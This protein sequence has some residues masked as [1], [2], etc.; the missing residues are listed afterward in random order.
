TAPTDAV[1]ATA[2]APT[3]APPAG[4]PTSGAPAPTAEEPP[5][6]VPPTATQPFTPTPTQEP[7]A[8]KIT[9]FDV[10]PQNVAPGALVTVTWQIEEA[11]RVVIS[12]FGDVP[13]EGQRQYRLDQTTDFQLTATAPGGKESLRVVHIPVR[14]LP[15][16]ST[17][18][19]TVQITEQV[20]AFDVVNGTPVTKRTQ[21]KGTEFEQQNVLISFFRLERAALSL[22]K[23]ADARTYSRVGEAIP[24]TLTAKNN[25]DVALREVT[26][27][28]P[29]V[30]LSECAPRTLD[31]GKTLVCRG[32]HT[33]TSDDMQ[34]ETLVNT[35]SAAG[36]TADGQ[37]ISSAA[38][39]ATITRV[40]VPHLALT[41]RADETEYTNLGDTLH[42]TL[43]ATND[44][45]VV[46]NN[47]IIRDTYVQDFSCT[48]E[49][50]TTLNP[51]DSLTCTG[52]YMVSFYTG[53]PG[54]S[55]TNIATVTATD[56]SN[57][58]VSATASLT[59]PRVN[60][61]LSLTKRANP[62]TFDDAGEIITYTMITTN[63][64]DVPLNN[65]SISDSMLATL[66]CT[67]SQPTTLAPGSSL[68]CTGRYTI[69][70]ADDDRC[71]VT[72]TATATGTDRSGRTI[73]GGP[74]SNV[75]TQICL[76][77]VGAEIPKLLSIAPVPTSAKT[78]FTSN[79]VFTAF[80][81]QTTQPPCIP[82]AVSDALL[83]DGRV[84]VK[85]LPVIY[86]PGW[87][88]HILDRYVVTADR[89]QG[90]FINDVIG[91]I[92]FPH[93]VRGVSITI[94]HPPDSRV[95]YRMYVLDATGSIIYIDDSLKNLTA[96]GEYKLTKST[97]VDQPIRCILIMGFPGD[98]S[99][100]PAD[101]QRD[102]GRAQA[103]L[104]I[105]EIR[106]P[107]TP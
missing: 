4:E 35:A 25:G 87:D 62:T 22:S 13:P 44:G 51:G 15:P 78:C 105:K 85:Y 88:S 5:T 8:P 71:T 50:P 59:I 47:V 81:F 27:N 53:G 68:R 72:N 52:T 100:Q 77:T 58:T 43:V 37:T 40:L 92:T 31:P 79:D 104:F 48:P 103:P 89:S 67:P 96:A 101:L 57:T 26:I 18:T 11:E 64:G 2:G 14:S 17:I 24:Y 10:S 90:N 106:I 95:S 32:S 80:L 99:V 69:S 54:S 107:I 36:R 20:I 82:Q 91:A 34:R 30:S 12:V 16:T 45:N 46:L 83:E 102:L 49:Q 86:P 28:D 73:T 84:P 76:R 61:S 97:A 98:G 74:V 7:G 39:S 21:I 63:T 65:V 66:N 70:D 75:I 6:A 38:A 1:A 9:L 33:V 93:G 42:Y 60:P 3:A 41:K 23:T 19:P 55:V 94:W 56:P 29:N